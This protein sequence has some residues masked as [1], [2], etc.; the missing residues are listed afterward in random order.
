MWLTDIAAALGSLGG[1]TA[2]LGGGSAS[3]GKPRA[4]SGTELT[5]G[6]DDGVA[7]HAAVY[8]SRR[9]AVTVVFCHGYLLD[10]TAWEAQ[11]AALEDVA[12]VVLWDL[13][14]HGRSGWGDPPNATVDQ[15]G[16]DLFAVLRRTTPRGP[17]ILVGHSMGAMAILGLAETHPELFGSRVVGVSL[18]STS[19]GGLASVTVG[20][21]TLAARVLHQVVPL[22]L[23]TLRRRAALVDTMR[24]ALG[25]PSFFLSRPYLF[26]SPVSAALAR[27]TTVLLAATPI[28]VIAEFYA[29]LIRHDKHAILPVLGRVPTQVIVG[30]RDHITPVEHA[31]VLASAIPG[32][33]LV[34]VPRAGHLLI[35]ERPREITDLLRRFVDQTIRTRRRHQRSALRIAGRPDSSAAGA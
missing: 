34:V 13:R 12:D 2:G 35:L 28:E 5:I 17:I 11:R 20:L 29:E 15:L 27:R 21:P 16:R 23:G 3:R 26:G 7:L 18:S 6:C 22:T 8:R 4:V 10:C 33:E 9:A 19:A 25:A 1:K 31:R 14:G 24:R 32:A 30:E